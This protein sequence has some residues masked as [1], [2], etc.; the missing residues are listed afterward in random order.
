MSFGTCPNQE[1]PTPLAGL[2]SD[3]A[4]LPHL[5]CCQ[6]RWGGPRSRQSEFPA[7]PL[8]HDLPKA[9]AVLET[10]C[11]HDVP[12]A[13]FDEMG[14]L[15]VL[16][17]VTWEAF[18][19]TGAGRRLQRCLAGPSPR[20]AAEH[21]HAPA[22]AAPSVHPSAPDQGTAASLKE[23]DL[24]AERERFARESRGRSPSRGLL[25]P[26]RATH[27]HTDGTRA[28]AVSGDA[29][30]AS[31]CAPVGHRGVLFLR[32]SHNPFSLAPPSGALRPAAGQAGCD[33]G[34]HRCFLLVS[35]QQ[36]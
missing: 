1:R 36:T 34:S 26:A 6:L 7:L 5:R 33:S 20:V 10:K 18:E 29:Y 12:S 13:V 23:R 11:P 22:A 8:P 31:W 9:G 15:R 21:R 25:P 27:P 24:Q 3:P 28:S 14:G 2:P 4:R 19:R 35:V 17:L 30:V 16:C 32:F